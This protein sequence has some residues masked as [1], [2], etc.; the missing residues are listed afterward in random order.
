MENIILTDYTLEYCTRC[1]SLQVIF[2]NGITACL[3]CGA[4]IAVCGLDCE[5]CEYATCPYS[6]RLEKEDYQKVVTN[7]LIPK[8]LAKQ[9]YEILSPQ[10]EL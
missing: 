6:S 10:W 3:N 7:P 5:T 2:A 9:I 1:D 4:P 8:E